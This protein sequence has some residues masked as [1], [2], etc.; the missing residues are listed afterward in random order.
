MLDEKT[1][2]MRKCR[3]WAIKGKEY[4]LGHLEE[5]EKVFFQTVAGVRAVKFYRT[6]PDEMKEDYLKNINDPA[7][8][9]LMEHISFVDARMEM[10]LGKIDT[11]KEASRWQE[12]YRS[13]KKIGRAKNQ[14]QATG[15]L[16]EAIDLCEEGVRTANGWNEFWRLFEVRRRL[17]ETEIKSR[18]AIENIMTPRDAKNF[19][20][21]VVRAIERHITSHA[22]KMA[23]IR[24]ISE[25]L[26]LVGES[27]KPKE[28]GAQGEMLMEDK[29]EEDERED[30]LAK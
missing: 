5:R 18:L 23:V 21:L 29:D 19:I 10:I 22:E 26:G 16:L 28:L 7:L 27:L 17:N 6:M 12:M 24:Q 1:L 14:E 2:A 13:M 30:I 9:S 25:V 11:I 20:A 15:S 3:R 4:C 8:L